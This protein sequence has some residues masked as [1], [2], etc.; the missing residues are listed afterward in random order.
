[1][2]TPKMQ[3]G[4]EDD[5]LRRGGRTDSMD[6]MFFFFGYEAANR[7]SWGLSQSCPHPIRAYLLTYFLQKIREKNR[8]LATLAAKLGR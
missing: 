4:G 6:L 3:T 8:N 5:S 1:M 7:R 2:D